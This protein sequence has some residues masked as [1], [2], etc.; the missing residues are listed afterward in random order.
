VTHPDATEQ[1][2]EKIMALCRGEIS[3]YKTEKRYLRKDG[4]VVWGS[5]YVSVIR[6]EDGSLQYL[7]AMIQDITDMKLSQQAFIKSEER[8]RAQYRYLP[9]PTF[10]WKHADGDFTLI[11][12]NRAGEQLTS[13]AVARLIGIHASVF[14][15]DYP[16]ALEEMGA[17][18]RE[19]TVRR[20]DLLYTYKLLP[21]QQYLSFTFAFVEPD[22]VMVHAENI[23]E[24][25][26]AELALSTEKER[27]AVTL[28]SIGD[29]VIATDTL[30]NIVLMN[31]VAEELTGWRQQECLGQPLS[32]IFRVVDAQSHAP[33]ENPIQKVL[34]S[35][36][37]AKLA[38]R[39]VL[40]ARDGREYSI[41]DSG[42]PIRD[43]DGRVIGVVLVFRDVTERIRLVEAVQNSQRLESLGVLAGGIAHDFNNLL[44]GI[45]GYI[46]MAR[47][48]EDWEQGKPL[49]TQA[50]TTMERARGLTRQLLTFAKGGLP[51]T[52]T[53]SLF[54]FVKDTAQFALSGSTVTLR[55][56]VAADLWPC[57]YDANQLGQV[58]DNLVINAQQAMP[59]GG[60]LAIRAENV[61]LKAGEHGLLPAGRYVKL[62]L[63]DT[64]CG[65]P[66][67]IQP[68]I[69]DPFFTTKQQGSGLGLAIVYSIVTKHG[70][71]IEVE[72]APGQGS[73][74]HIHLPAAAHPVLAAH[75]ALQPERHT[76]FGTI[77]LM[78]DEEVILTTAGAMLRS[79]GYDVVCVK[80][81][82]E[83]IAAYQT[84]ATRGQ[85]LRAMIL[86][87]TIPG[88]MGGKDTALQVR[89]VDP[90]L[91]IFVISGYA[92]DPVMAAPT[93]FG[94][95]ASINKP[96]TKAELAALLAR[97]LGEACA[98][99]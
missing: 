96:F 82:Q 20:R 13:G 74:F 50:L 7:L 89:E 43:N 84:A 62:S 8:F 57:D 10:T 16:G 53:A 33:V 19:R 22:L 59:T 68:R 23:T 75:G 98:A 69:F 31:Q 85:P 60:T 61:A 77:L 70:G 93:A 95:T 28:S 58:I 37:L 78:D 40:I 12:F 47:E 30:A 34:T 5:T 91:P 32:S 44:G 4:Q 24:R 49:L 79:M 97:H 73:A 83:A 15:A 67:E 87:L 66:P 35:G 94:L 46:E 51:V 64:G 17:C 72:S 80:E 39:T 18:Y 90:A 42:A 88:G 55:S 71:A 29:G 63:T 6:A 56:D 86:D 48:Q 3:S 38:S 41:A 45:F 11:D 65:I 26:A 92:E 52:S 76:G 36:K 14:F 54:P 9:V 1:D 25:K 2:I 27:L 99:K 21:Q 81:G